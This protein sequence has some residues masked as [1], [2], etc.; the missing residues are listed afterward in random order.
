MHQILK[1]TNPEKVAQLIDSPPN[2]SNFSSAIKTA[3]EDLK[4][5]LLSLLKGAHKIILSGIR[6]DYQYNFMQN[7]LDQ[8]KNKEI[9][10]RETFPSLSKQEELDHFNLFVSNKKYSTELDISDVCRSSYFHVKAIDSK[11]TSISNTIIEGCRANPKL[12]VKYCGQQTTTFNEYK[13]YELLIEF[14]KE[15]VDQNLTYLRVKELLPI[16]QCLTYFEL[17]KEIIKYIIQDYSMPLRDK[18][19]NYPLDHG[20]IVPLLG[21]EE[22][23]GDTVPL[24]GAEKTGE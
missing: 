20:F 19:I 23:S 2:G 6:N 13:T 9:K 5:S 12:K 21:W 24:S 3:E 22:L 18:T 14:A 7:I 17:P 16:Y 10:F 4:N 11:N 15:R 1:Q 8:Q